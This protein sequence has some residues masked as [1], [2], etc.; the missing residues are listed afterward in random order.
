MALEGHAALAGG[1]EG[2]GQSSGPVVPMVTPQPHSWS[3][4]LWRLRVPHPGAHGFKTQIV[5][6]PEESDSVALGWVPGLWVF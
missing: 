4:G 1:G 2:T 3:P 6:P 5:S